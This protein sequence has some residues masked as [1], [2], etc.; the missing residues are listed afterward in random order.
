MLDKLK[1]SKRFWTAMAGALVVAIHELV[2]IPEDALWPVVA[3]LSSLVLG[4]SVRD[5]E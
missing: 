4:Y 3:V 5:P 2:G 1:G